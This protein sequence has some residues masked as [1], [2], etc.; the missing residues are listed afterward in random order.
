MLGNFDPSHSSAFVNGVA[1]TSALLKAGATKAALRSL[2][3]AGILLQPRKGIFTLPSVHPEL[4]RALAEAGHP[5][6]VT[7]ARLHG[8]W[9]IEDDRLH[10]WHGRA[11]YSRPRDGCAC[12]HHW[13]DGPPLMPGQLPSISRTLVQIAHCLGEEAFFAGLES[14]LRQQLLTPAAMKW[15]RGKI[16]TSLRWLL[17]FARSDADSGLE[18]LVRLR[19]HHLG[20][21]AR[22]QVGIRGTGT[23]DLLVGDRLI[24][25]T[26]GRENHESPQKR[27]GDLMRDVNSAR[28]GFETLRLNYAMVMYHWALVEAAILAKVA[29]GAHLR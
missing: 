13:D 10:V 26:D 22:T 5:A 1:R 8:L 3:R 18:S 9:I 23:V 19:L 17:N 16:P 2:V 21:D 20:I 6:C 15:M 29:A 4:I 27:H 12:V 28:L 7:A 24:I 25:E 11:G 14:A